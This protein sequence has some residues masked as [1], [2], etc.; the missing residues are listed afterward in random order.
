[1]KSLFSM[2]WHYP[3]AMP[4]GAGASVNWARPGPVGDEGAPAGV[5]IPGLAGPMR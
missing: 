4:V 1:M 2:N 3:T 5:P